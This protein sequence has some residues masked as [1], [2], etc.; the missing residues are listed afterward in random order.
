MKYYLK[1]SIITITPE[2]QNKDVIDMINYPNR[3]NNENIINTIA[4]FDNLETAFEVLNLHKNDVRLIDEFCKTNIDYD[5]PYGKTYEITTY[6]IEVVHENQKARFNAEDTDLMKLYKRD[7]K[8]SDSAIYTLSKMTLS[9]LEIVSK[10]YDRKITAEDARFIFDN[11]IRKIK[12]NII[13]NK[14]KNI[15]VYDLDTHKIK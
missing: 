1:K 12:N 9:D 14:H 2:N 3:F 4:I 7:N 8:I 10:I 15:L 13:F 5:Y 6:Y 11:K